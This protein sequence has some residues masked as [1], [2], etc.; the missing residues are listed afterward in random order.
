MKKILSLGGGGIRGIVP[1]L[2]LDENEPTTGKKVAQMIDLIDG[3]AKVVDYQLAR[4]L[5]PGRSFRFQ[6]SLDEASDDLDNPSAA[7]INALRAEAQEILTTQK[8]DIQKV[9]ERV[10]M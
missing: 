7:S 2:V 4:I 10:G 3:V 8:D 1:A 9:C 5:G 6:T